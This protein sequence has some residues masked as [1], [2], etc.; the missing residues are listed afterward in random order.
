MAAITIDKSAD[1]GT[2]LDGSLDYKTSHESLHNA[3]GRLNISPCSNKGLSGAWNNQSCREGLSSRPVTVDTHQVNFGR[4][5]YWSCVVL[6]LI[7]PFYFTLVSH[8]LWKT[9]C[10]LLIH[11]QYEYLHCQKPVPDNSKANLC[12]SGLTT[13]LRWVAFM[14]WGM[15]V[16]TVGHA[17]SH[18][19]LQ[20]LRVLYSIVLCTTMTYVEFQDIKG[21][22]LVGLTTGISNG[23]ALSAVMHSLKEE[24][25]GLD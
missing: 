5:T 24:A 22:V 25:S 3:D 21:V 2:L 1:C 9:Q 7:F 18:H 15:A 17:D 14:S 8:I 6:L 4:V 23:L 20:A 12:Q 19:R 11:L 10:H 16:S 13:F